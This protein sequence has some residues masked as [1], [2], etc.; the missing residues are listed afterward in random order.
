[1]SLS[2]GNIIFGLC[3]VAQF[4]KILLRI[5]VSFPHEGD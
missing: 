5:F 1:M 4:A 2:Y 3:L